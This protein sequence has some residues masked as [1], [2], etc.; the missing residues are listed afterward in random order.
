MHVDANIPYGCLCTHPLHIWILKQPCP[1]LYIRKQG[2]PFRGCVSV[3][4]SKF[5]LL[6]AKDWEV[7]HAY[8]FGKIRKKKD[9]IYTTMMHQIKLIISKSGYKDLFIKNSSHSFNLSE[10]TIQV[11]KLPRG[12][13]LWYYGTRNLSTLKIFPFFSNSAG[14]IIFSCLFV[15]LVRSDTH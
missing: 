12:T 10:W 1:D 3:G 15:F 2:I 6:N 4:K 11:I 7:K 14:K 13:F 9:N 5:R 8:F